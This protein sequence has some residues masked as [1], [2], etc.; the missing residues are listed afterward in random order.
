MEMDD[1]PMVT[2]AASM[3]RVDIWVPPTDYEIAHIRLS[4]VVA[5][6]SV[7]L[8]VTAVQ[9]NDGDIKHFE[10]FEDTIYKGIA[11]GTVNRSHIFWCVDTDKGI[12]QVRDTVED[13][14]EGSTQHLRLAGMSDEQRQLLVD[15]MH[16]EVV[17]P[18]GIK[19]IKKVEMFKKWRRYVP[20][21]DV[22]DPIIYAD[23]GKSI[24]DE[25][26]KNRNDKARKRRK[27]TTM[28]VA[29]WPWGG[30]PIWGTT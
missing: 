24:I 15:N 9:V 18:E 29:L 17:E 14:S 21:G 8:D 16:L 30:W 6:P 13:S 5:T 4:V 26:N 22:D 12:L 3:P 1:N 27:T 23:P 7:S 11:T 19:G 28:T 10:K 25:I 20:P 2:V